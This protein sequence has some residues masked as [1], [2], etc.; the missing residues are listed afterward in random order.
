MSY[1][2]ISRNRRS[3]FCIDVQPTPRRRLFGDRHVSQKRLSQ[4][5]TGIVERRAFR[6]IQRSLSG[7]W[8][9]RRD[10]QTWLLSFLFWTA[11]D[12]IFIGAFDGYL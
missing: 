6:I 3:S 2:L 7:R 11:C 8:I 12:R 4:G 10:C 9:C 1:S 5:Q